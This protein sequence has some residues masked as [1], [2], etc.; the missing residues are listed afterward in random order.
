MTNTFSLKYERISV[1][2]YENADDPSNFDLNAGIKINA[3]KDLSFAFVA[4]NI[5]RPE[6]MILSEGEKLQTEFKTGVCYNWRKS[7]N[8][9][10]D[11]VWDQEDSFWNL[12]GEMWFYNVFAA[13]IGMNDD[14]LTTGFGIKSKYWTLDGA[15]L[16]H[17]SLGSTYRISLG[18]KFGGNR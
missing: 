7:V 12:G 14:K 17:T 3:G 9:T 15:L 18:L 8:F 6:F 10:A 13:R 11:Y 4:D 1:L 5:L 16:S 2:N